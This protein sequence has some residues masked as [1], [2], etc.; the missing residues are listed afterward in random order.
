MR[1]AVRGIGLIAPFLGAVFGQGTAAVPAAFDIADV[2]VSPK[3]LNARMSGGVLRGTRFEMKQ[4]TMVD[5]VRIAYGLD[6]EKVLGGPSW[7][8]LD[9]FDVLAKAPPNTAP[10]TAMPMLQAL[11]ADRFK[12]V[13]R[14]E[15]KP[16]PA[17]VLSLGKGKPKMKV[18]DGSG[19]PG[20]RPQPQTAP[21]APGEIPQI[22]YSCRNVTMDMFVMQVHNYANGYLTR[23][24]TNSTELSGTWDFDLTWTGRGN[25]VAAGSAGVSLFD[26][27]DKQLGMKME[28]KDLP[29]PVIQIV[30]V[31][32]TPTENP[33][34]VT[35]A[36]P[37]PPPAEFE[38]AEIKP[39]APGA[40]GGRLALQPSGRLD[41]ANIPLKTFILLAW[42]I[43]G[44]DTIADVPKFAESEN[45]DIIAKASTGGPGEVPQMDV[46]TVR[47]M[48]QKL[49][50]DRFK[51]AVHTEDRQVNGYVLTSVKPKMQKADPSGRTGCK[52]PPPGSA[53][54][55]DPRLTN[56]VLNAYFVCK[57]VTM[58]Q[59]AEQLSSYAN[60]YLT[61]PL[62]DQTGLTDA[63]DL[64]LSWSG[65]G[66]FRGGGVPGQ[67][68][69]QADGASEPNG[70]I[71]LMEAVSRQLGLK[72]EMQK[73]QLPIL[74]VDHLE[75]SPTEN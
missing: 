72:M 31:N 57:N 50:K 58:A 35:A 67:P 8:E 34:G 44:E 29:M 60:G 18:A 62:L 13:V 48:L 20:C 59:F 74:V 19:E 7:V 30:S 40:T 16:V 41:A 52:S 69:G 23:P 70:A 36:L 28:P 22:H 63:Y 53:D 39:S 42:N 17:F 10:E 21:P 54:S 14:Q 1:Q 27:I 68:A 45:F 75:Q 2:H 38:V 71:S 33:P 11:L 61:I 43:N 64:T 66:V 65:I 37:P 55:K 51:L 56:P 49:L 73:H 47:L 15:S 24:A 3:T 4:A 12:L 5:L 46:D 9:R 6:A 26:A 32:R 25:L